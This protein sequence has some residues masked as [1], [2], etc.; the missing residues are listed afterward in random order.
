MSFSKKTISGGIVAILLL[1]IGAYYGVAYVI[2]NQLTAIEARCER[3]YF[4]GQ[5]ENTPS[6]FY[7]RFSFEDDPLV[8][9]PEYAMPSYE[10]VTFTPRDENLTLS[11]W[12]IPAPEETENV[13]IIVHGIHSC[14]QSSSNLIPAGML[15]HA[16]FNVLMIELRNHGAS[17]IED[18]RNSVGNREHKDVLGAFDYLQEQ[19]FDA[20]DIG[21]VGISFGA[22][23][24]AIAF[25][26]EPDIPALW[27]DSP[28]GNIKEVVVNELQLNGIPTFF[29]TGALQIGQLN[30]VP[31]SLLSPEE[32]IA[33]HNERPI[34]IIHGTEDE[35]V[36]FRFGEQ[37]YA[38]A[39]SNAEF[40][41][42]EGMEHVEA[43]YAETELYET[44]LLAF[45]TETLVDENE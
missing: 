35:R 36:P 3:Y 28:F 12:Y 2:Y 7:S 8:E 39:G 10:D 17:E 9:M 23:T 11:G 34:T 6:L 20:G 4:E 15:H 40:I 32:E 33:N 5:R 44:A 31:L 45:F 38:N 43:M 27:L 14:K 22:G 25:G 21:L 42:V 30:G 1:L 18:G 19:G 41:R 16:G 24:S 13:I 26:Q 37:V 29:S